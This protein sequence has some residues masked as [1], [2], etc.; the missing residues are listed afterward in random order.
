MR[1]PSKLKVGG[2]NYDVEATPGL[3]LEKNRNAEQVPIEQ[4]IRYD[5][6][7]HRNQQEESFLHEIFEAIRYHY[8]IKMDHDSLDRMSSM[9]YTVL[10]DNEMLK[11]T[12]NHED[13]V[14]TT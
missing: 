12:A 7:L 5:P 14:G 10:K 11:E 1:I 9:L 6:I 3:I 8:N 4:I 13:N 2:F